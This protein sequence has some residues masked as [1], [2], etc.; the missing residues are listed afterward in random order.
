M[1]KK[2]SSVLRELKIP[3]V[4]IGGIPASIWGR[5]RM[6]V[7]T[8]IVLS[9]PEERIDLFMDL[10]KKEK[11]KVYPLRKIKEKLKAGLPVKIAYTKHFSIDIRIASYSIDRKAMK[12]AKIKK[13]FNIPLKICSPED[14]IV[15]KLIRFQ[16]IDIFD[17][18]NVILRWNKKLDWNYIRNTL[19]EFSR[20]TGNKKVLAN[21][22]EIKE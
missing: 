18:K 8:D 11:F 9:L 10:L 13:L 3:Y 19:R 5:P 12:R 20:E 22:K 16:E 17:I 15:Y 14:L 4:I 2:L 1:I 6:T 7:D 21:L